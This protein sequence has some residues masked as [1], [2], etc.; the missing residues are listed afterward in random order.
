[1]K[2][3]GDKKKISDKIWMIIFYVLL[4]LTVIVVVAG[5]IYA[6]S[7]FRS[8]ISDVKSKTDELTVETVQLRSVAYHNSLSGC[9]SLGFGTLNGHDYYVC[10]EV[11]EDDGIKLLKL[12]AD[13]TVI[14]DTITDGEAYAEIESNGWGIVQSIKLYV[15]TDTIQTE[16]D[17]SLND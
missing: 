5:G 12:D 3:N 2:E 4:F 8:G 9:F 14:Y 15:P 16:Y 1:M 17:F 6:F 13:K 7:N 11:L 10:Y